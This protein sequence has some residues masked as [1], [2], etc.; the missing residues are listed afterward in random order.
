[1][2]EPYQ[3]QAIST[4]FLYSIGT[5]KAVPLYAMDGAWGAEGTAPTPF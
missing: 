4:K 2:P 1:M 5:D 3:Y